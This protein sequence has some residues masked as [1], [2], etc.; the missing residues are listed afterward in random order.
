MILKSF[1]HGYGTVN[2]GPES[3]FCS[4]TNLA[5]CVTQAESDTFAEPQCHRLLKE[6]SSRIRFSS[7]VL[8]PRDLHYSNIK[9]PSCENLSIQ[10]VHSV[11]PNEGRHSFFQSGPTS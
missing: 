7:R 5:S 2:E 3:S 4:A 9:W 10:C 1:L 6:M 11:L 8:Y